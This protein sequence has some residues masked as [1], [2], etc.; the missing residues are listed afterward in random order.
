[1]ILTCETTKTQNECC[2]RTVQAR[3]TAVLTR[4][5]IKE[6]DVPVLVSG[7]CNRKSWM[8]HDAVH[9]TPH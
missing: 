1:M 9:L 6:P 2:T 8:T 7:D 3:H 4:I 5:I